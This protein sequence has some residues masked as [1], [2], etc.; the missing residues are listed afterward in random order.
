MTPGHCCWIFLDLS[1]CNPGFKSFCIFFH[2][3]FTVFF[4]ERLFDRGERPHS[5][6]ETPSQCLLRAFD[7]DQSCTLPM[8]P[9]DFSRASKLDAFNYN[10]SSNCFHFDSIHLI[11][12]GV[13][14]HSRSF[15]QCIYLFLTGKQMNMNMKI[16]QLFI[17][18]SEFPHSGK[19]QVGKHVAWGSQG[20]LV[21]SVKKH[22]WP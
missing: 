7:A 16:I 11:G 18:F 17:F 15:F 13:N 3:S 9:W 2:F 20:W 21:L 8:I 22:E 4:T 1:Q 14:R 5:E 10:S 6:A 12:D 19:S